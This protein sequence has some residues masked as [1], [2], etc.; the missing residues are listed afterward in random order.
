MALNRSS[1]G[2]RETLIIGDEQNRAAGP[3]RARFIAWYD[4][5]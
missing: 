3:W 5:G 2:R 1:D 4:R